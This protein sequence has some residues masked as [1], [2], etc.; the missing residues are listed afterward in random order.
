[1]AR[2]LT[3]NRFVGRSS[4]LREL[5]QA[6]EAARRRQP[7]LLL[8]RGD[9]GVGK[10][11]LI[12][13][14][15]RLLSERDVLV[16]RGEAVEQGEGEL[17]YAP[18]TSALRPLVRANDP[19]IAELSSGSRAQ[20][21]AL[22]PG[23][24]DP[25]ASAAVHDPSAQVRL[26]EALLELLDC[27]S[28]RSPVTLI[29]EDMHW[30]DR[31]TRTFVSFLARSLRQEAMLVVLSYRADELHRRHPLRPLLSE[32]DRLESVRS[33]DLEPFN[34]EE[35]SEVLADILDEVPGESLVQ[36][37]Y[38]RSEGNPL[39]T[40]E[41]LAAGLDGRGAPPASLRDAF[42]L[43]IERLSPEAQ[44]AARAIAVG[45]R[46]S[47][48]VLADVTGMERS[49]LQ[50]ALREALA[51][52][53]LSTDEEGRFRFRH[54]LLR[55]VLYDDLLPGERGDLHLVLARTL[56]ALAGGG[57]EQEA[58]QAAAVAGHYAAAGDQPAALRASV[59]AALAARGVH[60]YAEAAELAERALELWP[61][62]PDA[63]RTTPL[64]RVDLL[65]LAASAH[66]IAGDRERSETLLR[67]ALEEVDSET[68]PERY[69]GLL[70]RLARLQWSLNRGAE[71]VETAQQALALLPPG[72]SSRERPALMAWLARTL[73]LRGKFRDA[74]PDAEA[75][76]AAAVAA[77]DRHA[78]GEVLNTLGM[79]H[80]SLGDV[81]AGVA[82]L[83]RAIE[84]GRE[85]HDLD[86]LGAAYTNLADMLHI[87]GRT[88][89]A[90]RVARAGLAAI[91]RRIVRLYEWSMLS[92][93]ILAHD[94]GDWQLMR[95]HLEPATSLL[96]R[97]GIFRSLVLAETALGE[98]RDEEAAQRL[99]D[100][101]PLVESSSEP[102]WIGW[103]GALQRRA[104]PESL[105]ASTGPRLRRARAGPARGLH[106]RRDANRA[107]QR[108]RSPG[109][110]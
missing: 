41:L 93:A 1:M 30:A 34:R 90:L 75:A 11:R 48:P 54:A 89:D 56:E 76:L 86:N 15:E 55:E 94:A 60:A 106:G 107:G 104:P 91:P 18:L 96:D 37:L 72:E 13:E 23:L 14:L 17:P 28:E 27:L 47:E 6:A 42:M 71:G 88:A 82:M 80:I 70:S 24:A 79:A 35:V 36:R 38:A 105:R 12:G 9:S 68:E 102:Q 19:A 65:T 67:H 20:L 7:A 33:I 97:R 4:E 45:G 101:E 66:S 8:L 49:A 31:S 83:E 69:A 44:R 2:R 84:I 85:D 62:V 39:F 100:V 25:G 29:L 5:E 73:Y 21:A 77:G 99:E 10:T 81:E 46:L 78:E 59:Q 16:L 74:I 63:E 32:L 108:S 22:F 57:Q 3:S 95:A 64:S 58:E 110:G 26:F 50:P 51:E 61:R 52:H 103:F 109:R 92:V 43:R 40:E 87:S 53:V 98:G